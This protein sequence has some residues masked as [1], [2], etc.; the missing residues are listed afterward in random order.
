MRKFLMALAMLTATMYLAQAK[1]LVVYYSFTNNVHRIINELRSQIEADVI[2][3]EPA[4]KGLDYAANNYAIGSA[5]ISAIRENPD[6]PASYPTIDPVDVNLDEYS[7]IIIGAPLWWSN[8]A[9]PL[10]T[11]LFNNG[12]KMAGKNI[13]LIVS[14]ASSGISGVEADARR[15]IP[16]GK[17]LS[18]SLW[19]RASQI[20]NA[21]TMISDW[22]KAINYSSLDNPY[23]NQNQITIKVGDETSLTASLND[24]SSAKALL[25]LLEAGPVTIDMHDYANMEKVGSLPTSL[26]RNDTYFTA[27]P[28]DLVLYLGNQFVIYYDNNSYNFTHLGKINGDYTGSQLK[29]ILGS[30]NVTVTLSTKGTDG[31]NDI[32]ENNGTGE[33]TEIYDFEGRKIKDNG[34]LPKGIYLFKTI[35]GKTVRTTKVVR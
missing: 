4:E 26:P 14:S 2:R 27:Q 13:G 9:A 22:L 34:N 15:L 33:V 32:S 23:M 5:L 8:M 10:Q 18:P 19:V 30:G 12:A 24:N 3:I 6:D 11:F 25:K 21:S 20:S 17:F 35:K 29:S 16:N 31:I 7:T 28:G 1:T